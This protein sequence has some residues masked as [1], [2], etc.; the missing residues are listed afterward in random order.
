MCPGAAVAARRTGAGRCRDGCRSRARRAV[1]G[2]S[3]ACRR[4]RSLAPHRRG[5]RRLATRGDRA[6]HMTRTY[7]VPGRVEL[8]GKHVDYAGGRSLT[9]AV[10]LVITARANPIRDPVV[11]VAA[12]GRRGR[13]EVPLAA[14]AAPAGPPWAAYVAAVADRKS[15]G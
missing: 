3:D 13:V 7:V 6:P 9:C 15:V 5:V 1:S 10:D 12:A 11:R 4:T 14:S 8:V 2:D